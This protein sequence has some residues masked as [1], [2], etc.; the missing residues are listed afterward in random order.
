MRRRPRYSREPHDPRAFTESF[1]RAY[2]RLARLRRR[3]KL[4]PTWRRWLRQTLPHIEG[5]WVLEAR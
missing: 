2:F 4:F 3:R 5:P 1:D